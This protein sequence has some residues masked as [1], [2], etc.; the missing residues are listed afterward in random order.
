M[1]DARFLFYFYI[2]FLTWRLSSHE[3]FIKAWHTRH[4]SLNSITVLINRVRKCVLVKCRLLK[5]SVISY[6]LGSAVCLNVPTLAVTRREQDNFPYIQSQVLAE[7]NKFSS[8]ASDTKDHRIHKRIIRGRYS[9]W[10]FEL[11]LCFLWRYSIVKLSSLFLVKS[12][13]RFF[14]H[15]L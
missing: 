5:R 13:N 15:W 3:I 2:L 8:T 1:P 11:V 12:I 9:A 4:N 6:I 10:S 14:I 7:R